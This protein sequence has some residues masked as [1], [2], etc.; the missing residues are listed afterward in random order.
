MQNIGITLTPR[1]A[2]PFQMKG[3]VLQMLSSGNSAGLTVQFLKGSQV[4]YTVTGVLTG[5]KLTP[6][7]GFDSITIESA[8]GD[9]ISG[10][11][12]DGNVDIQVLETVTQISNTTANP[13]PVQVADGSTVT[14]TATNVGINN[15]SANPVP[16]S[17]VNEPGAPFA[18]TVSNT[19]GSPLPVSLVSEPGAPVATLDTKAQTP[20]TV[21]PVTLAASATGTVLLASSATRRAARFYN[22]GANPVAITP[23]NAT[24]FV[25]AAIML[26]P[27]DFWNETDAPGAAWFASTGAS[28]GSTVNLQ[29]VAP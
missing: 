29:T 21:A 19:A 9:T 18:V 8:T 5:W 13:V 17:I 10:I 11:V 12:T 14:V 2:Q 6:K 27:G 28:G 24:T 7:G 4:Q 22:A 26:N 15:S 23:D 1:Y 25:N 3:T 20:A 16:V